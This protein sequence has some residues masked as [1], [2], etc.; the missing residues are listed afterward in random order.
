V[1]SERTRLSSIG[2]LEAH[3]IP[4]LHLSPVQSLS[5]LPEMVEKQ[6]TRRS[7]ASYPTSPCMIPRSVSDSEAIMVRAKLNEIPDAPRESQFT[8]ESS[9]ATTGWEKTF[10]VLVFSKMFITRIIDVLNDKLNRVSRG[11]RFVAD[12]LRVEKRRM[13]KHYVQKVREFFEREEASGPS[14]AINPEQ[15]EEAIDGL[16]KSALNKQA[17]RSQKSELQ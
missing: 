11:F 8:L 13:K 2:P 12:K 9:A 14:G 16:E 1:S 5:C 17:L 3:S 4:T 15:A 6:G 10:H 7:D